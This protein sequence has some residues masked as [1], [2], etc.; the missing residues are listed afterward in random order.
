M[1]VGVNCIKNS[2]KVSFEECI[3][4][5]ACLP[6]QIIKS[7]RVY[8][9]K[10]K[11]NTYYVKEIIGCMRKA[12]FNRKLSQDEYQ[13]LLQLFQIKRGKALGAIAGQGWNELDGSVEYQI[14]GEPIKLTARLDCYDPEKREIIEVKTKRYI[15]GPN[16]PYTSDR[17]QVQCYASIFKSIL[18]ISSLSILYLDFDHFRRI[19]LDI[20]D[21][22]T[23][24]QERTT[25]LHKHIRD[26]KIPNDEPSWECKDCTHKE[27]CSTLQAKANAITI[28]VADRA[29][30]AL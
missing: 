6:P 11:R 23:W 27:S 20:S 15:D 29:K 4:C 24:M 1:T 3:E 9:N 2:K 8:E 30:T 14:D 5:A 10:P 26:S 19:H 28:Q 16:L 12:Y 21:I 13:T 18:P 22:S 17:M 7:L 25:K